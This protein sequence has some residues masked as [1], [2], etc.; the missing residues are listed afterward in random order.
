MIVNKLSWKDRVNFYLT[1]KKSA[2]NLTVEASLSEI[3]HISHLEIVTPFILEWDSITDE[4][5]KD[6]LDAIAK[7]K[8]WCELILRYSE[9]NV[10]KLRAIDLDVESNAQRCV[11]ILFNVL[12]HYFEELENIWA[13]ENLGFVNAETSQTFFDA[14]LCESQEIV[15]LYNAFK[16]LILDND[17]SRQ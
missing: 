3:L 12:A 14:V 9:S 2:K 1:S 16:I 11:L 13:H 6:M 7:L 10:E 15:D 17:S 8:K 5:S 4:K